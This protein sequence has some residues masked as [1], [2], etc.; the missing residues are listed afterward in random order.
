ME[1]YSGI[2]DDVKTLG[3]RQKIASDFNGFHGNKRF[4]SYF[5]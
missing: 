4:S 1:C 3:E 2:L 5:I